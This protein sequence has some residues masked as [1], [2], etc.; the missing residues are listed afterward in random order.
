MRRAPEVVLVTV[1]P[2]PVLYALAVYTR[3]TARKPRILLDCHFGTFDPLWASLPLMD[4]LFSQVDALIVHNPWERDYITARWPHLPPVYVLEDPPADMRAPGS[5]WKP[6]GGGDYVLMPCSFFWDE[7]IGAVVE[8][9]RLC[10]EITFVLTGDADNNRAD[11]DLRHLP[12]NCQHVGYLPVD[13]YNACVAGAGR[14][15]TLRRQ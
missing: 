4:R 2:T 6:R 13:Q 9:A 12:P 5:S 10:P 1:P 3:M 7:P 8:A 15:E 14:H 11:H